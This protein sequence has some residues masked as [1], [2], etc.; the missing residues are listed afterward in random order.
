M[1][2]SNLVKSDPKNADIHSLIPAHRGS[3]RLASRRLEALA[4]VNVQP[5][6]IELV[7]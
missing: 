6:L 3:A 4:A 5:V 2:T 1:P 7:I